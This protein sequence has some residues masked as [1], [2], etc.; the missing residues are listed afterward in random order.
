M[1]PYGKH[2]IYRPLVQPTAIGAFYADFPPTN[3][4]SC[5]K[6]NPNILDLYL[7]KMMCDYTN[8]AHF[9]TDELWI[10]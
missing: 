1:F 5:I 10:I 6:C 7:I 3:L 2:R 4:E 8:P 9:L